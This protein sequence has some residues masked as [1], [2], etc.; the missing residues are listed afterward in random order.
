ML[1]PLHTEQFCVQF[2]AIISECVAAI[3]NPKRDTVD[4]LQESRVHRSLCALPR[5]G[6]G[7]LGLS[8]LAMLREAA[9]VAAE[10]DVQEVIRVQ[11]IAAHRRQQRVDLIR[12]FDP[13]YDPDMPISPL[14]RRQHQL[15]MRIFAQCHADLVQTLRDMGA[16]TRLALLESHSHPSCDVSWIRPPHPNAPAATTLSQQ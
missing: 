13:E 8:S 3:I 4:T 2:D 15:S 10:L 1:S 5:K 12:K 6:F 7:G 14:P 9:W 11:P 16:T